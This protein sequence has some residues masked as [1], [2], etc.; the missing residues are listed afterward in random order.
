MLDEDCYLDDEF[1]YKNRKAVMLKTWYF[2]KGEMVT[3]INRAPAEEG[4][5]YFLKGFG[6]VHGSLLRLIYKESK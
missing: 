5:R 6:W 4:Y 3:I 2:K 1:F